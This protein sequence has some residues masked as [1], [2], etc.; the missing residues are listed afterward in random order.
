VGDDPR[1]KEAVATLRKFGINTSLV[2]TIA[3]APT[4]TVG[5]T[6]DVEGKPSFEISPGS[7]WDQIAWT[8][9]LEESVANS[10]AVYF[11]T[12]GQRG[13]TA[14]TTIQRALVVARIRC[15]PRV[16]DVNLRKPFDDPEVIRDS[17]ALAS[18]VKLSEEELPE[19]ADA[20]D[21]QV[22]PNPEVTL[23]ILLARY[24]LDLIVMTR[25]AKGALLISREVPLYQPG[26][27]TIVQDTVGAGDAFTAAFVMGVL[28]GEEPKVILQ[29][30]CE[31]AARVCSH[32]GAVLLP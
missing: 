11:G 4:G 19:V 14:R 25:G 28:R 31:V 27:P 29:K 22:D 18:I 6:L 3:D 1:G 7:A 21:V 26:I 12:L 23:S 16:L 24:S 20:A 15:V 32:A 5:V 2:Q 9:S 13:A 17:L 30:A 8:T 10:D